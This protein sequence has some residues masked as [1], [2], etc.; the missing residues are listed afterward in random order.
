MATEDEPI[1]A[2]REPP[3][4]DSAESEY[5]QSNANQ[6][7]PVFMPPIPRPNI[8]ADP[9]SH[10]QQENAIS[11]QVEGSHDLQLQGASV[12]VEPSSIQDLCSLAPPPI[13]TMI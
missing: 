11:I 4:S 6:P 3:S 13:L 12:T 1:T 10:Q 8:Y 9:S 5:N 2:A 7:T